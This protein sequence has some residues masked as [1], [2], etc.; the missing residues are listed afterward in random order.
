MVVRFQSVAQR[1]GDAL[2]VDYVRGTEPARSP[3]AMPVI[4]DRDR[5]N[6]I[7]EDI[8]VANSFSLTYAFRW[9]SGTWCTTCRRVQPPS[10]YGVSS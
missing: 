8:E 10:R 6:E 3:V 1:E 5:I 2:R 4:R 9:L 7:D